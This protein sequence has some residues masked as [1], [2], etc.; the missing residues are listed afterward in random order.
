[1]SRYP[2]EKVQLEFPAG[3]VEDGEYP[4]E[5]RFLIVIG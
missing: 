1:M 5:M 2:I 3:G 4:V